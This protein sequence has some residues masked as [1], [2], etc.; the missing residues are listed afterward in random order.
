MNACVLANGTSIKNIPPSVCARYEISIGLN[1]ILFGWNDHT[2]W[3]PHPLPKHILR[4]DTFGRDG[5]EENRVEKKLIESFLHRPTH[6]DL[7]LYHSDFRYLFL[8]D[9]V[10]PITYGRLRDRKDWDGR[11]LPVSSSS[12]YSAAGMAG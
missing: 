2:I 7:W 5:H 10:H 11:E 8:A 1:G 4:L 6:Y 9:S 12:T 3:Y